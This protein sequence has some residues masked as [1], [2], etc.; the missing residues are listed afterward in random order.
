MNTTLLASCINET[1]VFQG[2][3]WGLGAAVRTRTFD[4]RGV[5]MECNLD[6]FL[7]LTGLVLEL[8]PTVWYLGRQAGMLRAGGRGLFLGARTNKLTRSGCSTSVEPATPTGGR[9]LS[10]WF[11]VYISQ[12]GRSFLSIPLSPTWD[13]ELANRY[14]QEFAGWVSRKF[15]GIFREFSFEEKGLMCA[16]TR[17]TYRWVVH[18][19]RGSNSQACQV[20]KVQKCHL[21][22]HHI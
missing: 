22:R 6:R 14:F 17:A 13:W 7:S 5:F 19:P 11:H 18:N 21:I 4:N 3:K 15:R 9:Q 12:L 1:S 10:W 8:A 2:I 16:A 20:L